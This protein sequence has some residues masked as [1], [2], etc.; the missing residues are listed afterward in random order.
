MRERTTRQGIAAIVVAGV[1]LGAGA[2]ADALTPKSYKN[3]TALNKVYRHGVGKPGARD[4]TSAEPV[5]NFRVSRR[6]YRYNDGRYPVHTG[7]HDLD[8]DN[9]GIACEKL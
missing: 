9:D 3:C 5:T 1:A 8:R 2:T 4:H 7:E 6:L